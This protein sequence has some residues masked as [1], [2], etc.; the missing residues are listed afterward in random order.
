MLTF[1]IMSHKRDI[2]F[3]DYNFIYIV[4]EFAKFNNKEDIYKW[5]KCNTHTRDFEHLLLNMRECI[6][7]DS[8]KD[9]INLP[10]QIINMIEKGTHQD[11]DIILSEDSELFGLLGSTGYITCICGGHWGCNGYSSLMIVKE[12]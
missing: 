12:D 3:E 5:L 6:L 8:D 1:Y 4:V 9:M 10:E 2:H 11:Y 7:I